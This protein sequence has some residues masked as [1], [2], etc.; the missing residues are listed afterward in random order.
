MALAREV[1]VTV[2]GRVAEET[3]VGL[4][5]E[6][7]VEVE[8]VVVAMEGALVGVRAEVATVVAREVV[9]RAEETAPPPP[10]F[11]H[12]FARMPDVPPIPPEA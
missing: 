5:A 9:A 6:A 2:E 1:V 10:A 8:M 3:A 4:G 7:T 11:C 12:T